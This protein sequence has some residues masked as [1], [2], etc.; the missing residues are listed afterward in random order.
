M[1]YE[2]DRKLVYIAHPLA[3]K[4]DD[5]KKNFEENLKIIKRI[6]DYLIDEIKEQERGDISTSVPFPFAPQLYFPQ[7]I[8]ESKASKNEFKLFRRT[9]IKFCM[10]AL[11]KCDEVY[12][13]GYNEL[14][15]GVIDDIEMASKLGIPITFKEYPW[16]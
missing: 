8:D 9:A 11:S 12:V 7:F 1:D 5:I 4:D 2:L 6:C 10:I 14:S 15:G 13:Y 16:E 3:G